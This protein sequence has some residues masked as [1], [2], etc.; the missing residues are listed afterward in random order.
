MPTGTVRL[1]RIL[2]APAERVYR[3]FLDPDAMARWIPPYGFVC[4]VHE[5]NAHVGG[6][7]RMSFVNFSSGTGHSFGGTYQE[8]VQN[9]RLCYTDA[10]DDPNLPG[11][12]VTTVELVPVLCGTELSIVQEGLPEIIPVAMCELGWQESLEQLARLVEPEIP[13]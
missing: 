1:R 5:M 4:K 9:Q 10:F 12:M 3:A 11:T 2:R 7:Y 13:D 8:L 6:S